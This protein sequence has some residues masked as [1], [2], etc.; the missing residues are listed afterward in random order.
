MTLTMSRL[1]DA[2]A[3]DLSLTADVGKAEFFEDEPIFILVQLRNLGHDTAWV[4]DFGFVSPA[5]EV[6]VRRRDGKLVPIG[7]LIADTWYGAKWRGDP[8]ARG[9][10]VLSAETLQFR[11]GNEREYRRSL[12]PRHLAPAEYEVKV[13]FHVHWAIAQTQALTLETPSISFRIREGTT[14]EES[15]VKELEA[16]RTMAW[17]RFPMYEAALIKWVARH[18]GDDPFL[19]FL[20]S[21]W[22]Y[23]A[24]HDLERTAT[25]AATVNLDTLRTAVLDAQ[26]RTPAG[27][28]IVQTMV[29]W[30]P[31]QL[32]T[33]AERLGASH[34]GEMARYH[35]ERIHYGERL[36][37]RP[38]R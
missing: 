38:G 20:L 25:M 33:L 32:P 13:R 15:E 18:Q 27:A 14:A 17:D 10:S 11:A 36:K 7:G 2:L 6:S 29:A 12:F 4:G 3:Q 31:E 21:S 1:D 8:V 5:I 30:H 23:E 26:K 24:E 34:A 19:P 35:L 28:H 22:L 37:K 16:I 9:K